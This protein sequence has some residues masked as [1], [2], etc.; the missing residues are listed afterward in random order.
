MKKYLSN[1]EKA[2]EI[3][4]SIKA[5]YGLTSRDVSVTVKNC[6]YDDRLSVYIKTSKALPF[7]KEIEKL[8]N[9]YK[10]VD[11]DDVCGEILL[12]G[13]TFVRVEYNY[14]LLDDYVAKYEVLAEKIFS[15]AVDGYIKPIKEL[16]TKDINGVF[17][18]IIEKH[19]ISYKNRQCIIENPHHL[20]KCLAKIE[21][22]DEI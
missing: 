19:L 17:F 1:K 12:G 2:T 15:K 3:R 6:L 21:L 10:S 11:Y 7:Y 14:L 18:G 8:A 16:N 20:A 22:F 5:K 4:N 9:E 13:N